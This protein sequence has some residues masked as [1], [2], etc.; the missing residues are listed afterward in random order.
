MLTPRGMAYE[1]GILG[2][3]WRGRGLETSGFE[4]WNVDNIREVAVKWSM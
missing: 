4:D 2:I 1:H 3:G